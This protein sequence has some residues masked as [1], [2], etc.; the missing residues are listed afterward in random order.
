MRED[1]ESF[2]VMRSANALGRDFVGCDIAYPGIE[3]SVAGRWQAWI[4]RQA[5]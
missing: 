2:V 1:V 4:E 5:R 3:E